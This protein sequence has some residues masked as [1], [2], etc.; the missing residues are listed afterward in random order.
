MSA[1]FYFPHH[2]PRIG[3]FFLFSFF[4][5]S[6]MCW[7]TFRPFSLSVVKALMALS[8]FSASAMARRPVR[9]K[10]MV[11]VDRLVWNKK[12]SM[13]VD[14]MLECWL[15]IWCVCCSSNSST[16]DKHRLYIFKSWFPKQETSWRP[17]LGNCPKNRC[18]S[19][20]NATSLS[21]PQHCTQPGIET[22]SAAGR[23]RWAGSLVNPLM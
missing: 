21:R 23:M 1:L 14:C 11:A 16:G 18:I 17:M 15:V 6:N 12:L 10:G 13:R 3:V 20:V 2:F 8:C 5:W 9:T 22:R 19:S 7:L 4:S